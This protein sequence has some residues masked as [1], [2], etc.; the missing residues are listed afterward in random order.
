[1]SLGHA[2]QQAGEDEAFAFQNLAL[3]AALS[4]QFQLVETGGDHLGQLEGGLMVVDQAGGEALGDGHLLQYLDRHLVGGRAQHRFD[5][6]GLLG[7][8][9]QFAAADLAAVAQLQDGVG[10]AA[11][12]QIFVQRAVI[13][14]IDLRL[15]AFRP[16]ERRLGDVEIALLDQLGH[17]AVEEGQEER[18]DMAAVDV[19][20]G[21]DDDL[22]VARLVDLEV[23]APDAGAE[24]RDQRADFR[25]GQHLVEAGAFHVQDLAA[26]RQDGL[27]G[28]V[29]ALLR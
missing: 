17:L 15:A 6:A 11:I 2:A 21:H 13:L 1:M 22:V 16:V 9:A 3:P 20:V 23:L 26:Q 27:V 5:L 8:R 12:G 29:A 19:G 24:G 18:A 28:A 14:E 4:R 7:Q 10:Q 25:R